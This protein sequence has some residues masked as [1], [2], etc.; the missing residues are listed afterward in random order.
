MERVWQHVY[1]EELK[2][3]SEEGRTADARVRP[4]QSSL[5]LIS[6]TNAV[7][8]TP[9]VHKHTNISSIPIAPKNHLKHPVL[10]T[11]APLNPRTN[12]DTAAQILFE[13]FNVP[14][15]FTSVQAVLAL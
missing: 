6:T 8:F 3:M 15:L 5:L 14:A 11:E 10:L 9:C 12:R 13:T 1:S 2:T 7:F 4:I